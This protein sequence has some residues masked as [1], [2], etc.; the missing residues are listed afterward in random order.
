[1]D[2]GTSQSTA[3][4][5]MLVNAITEKPKELGIDPLAS[6]YHM[7]DSYHAVLE[8]KGFNPIHAILLVRDAR[9]LHATNN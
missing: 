4:H 9:A 7:D 2:Q 1:M 5:L 8:S 3:S 6:L